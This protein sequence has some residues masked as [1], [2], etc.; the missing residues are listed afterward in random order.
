MDA[1]ALLLP[2]HDPTRK[3]PLLKIGVKSCWLIAGLCPRFSPVTQ[4]V[5]TQQWWGAPCSGQMHPNWI[6]MELPK[7]LLCPEALST[8]LAPSAQSWHG[9]SAPLPAGREEACWDLSQVGAQSWLASTFT[10]FRCSCNR[11][12]FH[13]PCCR[14]FLLDR[15]LVSF[16][17]LFTSKNSFRS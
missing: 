11:W 14:F 17:S 5:F 13:I 6:L 12:L 16:L 1:K 4:H 10:I 9:C 2:C 7:D 8:L 15:N 3:L